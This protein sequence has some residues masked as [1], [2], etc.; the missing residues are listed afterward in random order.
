MKKHLFLRNQ[1]QQ[2]TYSTASM[3]LTVETMSI[4]TFAPGLMR[5]PLLHRDLMA[6]MHPYI[7]WIETSMSR[8]FTVVRV[9]TN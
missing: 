4:G 5:K 8:E 6:C 7:E 9:Q 2:K 3:Y 1:K